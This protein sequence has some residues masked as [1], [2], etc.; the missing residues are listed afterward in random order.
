MQRLLPCCTRTEAVQHLQDETKTQTDVDEEAR[1]EDLDTDIC[2][3]GT[4]KTLV[5][6]HCCTDN[7]RSSRV[8]Q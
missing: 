3:N 2:N 6:G 8:I 7:D 5:A 4:Q 1:R